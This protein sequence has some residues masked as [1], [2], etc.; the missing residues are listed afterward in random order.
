MKVFNHISLICLLS[1]LLTA[2]GGDNKSGKNNNHDGYYA[3]GLTG[4]INSNIPNYNGYSINQVLAENQ[5][6]NGLNQRIE[7]AP[8][9]VNIGGVIAS[10]DIYV[11]VTSMGDVGVLVG[12]GTQ[13]PTFV[14]YYCVRNQYYQNAGYMQSQVRS[15]SL[16]AYTYCQF[17][18]IAAASVM[19]SDGSVANFRMLDYGNS[20]GQRFTFCQ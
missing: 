2:C 7:G 4:G 3:S 15:M 13:A 6:T 16:G 14:G 8:V 12:N 10:G 5:C 11:G 19:L 1:A 18:P 20:R 9:Q 17:K